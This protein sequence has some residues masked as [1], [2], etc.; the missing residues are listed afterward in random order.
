MKLGR[1]FGLVAVLTAVGLVPLYG[2]PRKSPVTHS[3]WSRMLLR[4]M[5][6]DESVTRVENADAIFRTLAW[7]DEH[8][9]PASKYTRGTDVTKRGNAVDAT[10]AAGESAYDLPIVRPGDYNVRL[11][12]KGAP[13]KPFRVEI[14]KNGGADAIRTF[15]PT[16]NGDEISTVDLGWVT[17]EPGDHT[18]SVA[19]PPGTSLEYVQVAPPCLT[20][21]EPENGWRAAA[22]TTG[23]DL[24]LTMIQAMD[25]Q[26]E[27]APGAEPIEIRAEKF[28]NLSATIKAS[29][30]VGGADQLV[31]NPD[32]V[33]AIAVAEI[34]EDGLYSMSAWVSEGRGQAWIADSCRRST[35]CPAASGA[36]HWRTIM[37]SDFKKGRHTFAVLLADSASVGRLRL[38]KV[39]DSGDDYIAA[40]KRKGFDVG[41]PG[42]IT[43]EKAREAMDWLRIQWKRKF[44]EER[45]CTIDVP[46]TRIAGTAPRGEISGRNSGLTVQPPPSPNTPGTPGGN[47]PVPP[48]PGGG[49]G[50]TPPPTPPPPPATPTVTP[51]PP[52]TPTPPVPPTPTPSPTA[53]PT[54]GPTTISV[55]G[56]VFLDLNGDGIQGPNEPGIPG[57]SVS[58]VLANGTTRLVTTDANGI[59]S[60]VF[61]GPPSMIGPATID[62]VNS[63]LPPGMSQTAGIDSQTVNLVPGPN[64]VGADGYRPPAVPVNTGSL[65]GVVFQDT[66]GNGVQD[67][68]E[69]GLPGVTVIVTDV[70]GLPHVVTTDSYGVWASTDLPPG[71]ATVDVVDATLPAGVTQTAG[72]DPSTA[73][74]VAGQV[75]FGGYDGY[76]PAG[77]TSPSTGAVTGTIFLDSDGDGVRDPGEPGM[78]GVSVIVTASN[79]QTFLVTTDANGNYFV[80]NVPT[81]PATVDV[82]NSTLPPG[83][84]QTAGTDPTSINVTPGAPTNAGLDGY[85]P[86][87]T[88]PGPTGSVTGTIFFDANGNG[89]QDPG[90]P[91]LSG[92][93]VEIQTAG[94]QLIYAT[95]N[96]NGVYTATNVPAGNATVDVVNSTLPAGLTQ[97]AG[98]DPTPV[99]VPPAGTVNAGVDGYT[100][101]AQPT[102]GLTGRVFIDSNGDGVQ[103]PG[104]PGIP[105]VSVVV[106]DSAGNPHVVVTDS[107]GNWTA[108]GLPP[109]NATV[110][111]VNAT[112]P[113]GT[114][115]QTAGTDPNAV[116]VVAG[117]TSNGGVDGYQPPPPVGVTGTITGHVYQDT[118][119][120]GVQNGGEPNLPGVSIVVTTPGGQ[121]FTTLTDGSGNYSVPGVPAGN[122]TVDI[123]NSTLPPG[124]VQT[125]GTDPTTV[126]VP[127][128]GSVFEQNN[129]FEPPSP[130]G[131]GGVTGLVFLDS[132][133]NGSQDGG[134]PGIP[135][136]SVVITASN[137][138]TFVATTDSNGVYVVTN[139]PLGPA[140]VDVVNSTLPPNVTQTAGID[141][142]SVNVVAGPPT[143]AGIDGFRPPSVPP[144]PVGSVTG[145]VYLDTNG[146][147]VRDGGENGISGV[148]VEIVAANGQVFYAVTNVNGDYTVPNVP[149]G[150]AT[151]DVV[152]STLPPNLQQTGG[153]D[154]STVAVPAAGVG[155]A[156]SDG[157]QP[158]Q[159]PSGSIGTVTGVVFLDSNQNGVRDAG[160]PGLPGVQVLLTTSTGQVLTGVTDTD[161]VYSIQNAASGPAT[162][163]VV[164]GTLPPGLNQTAGIDPSPVTVL[165]NT[166]T[167]AGFDGYAPPTPPTTTG[168]VTGLVFQDLNGDGDQDPGELGL[169]GVQVVITPASGPPITVTTGPNG[170]YTAPT[171]PIGSATVD[172]VNSTLPPGMTQT[173]GVDTSTVNVLPGT[174]NNAGI[175][176]YQPPPPPGGGTVTG[177]VFF[178]T[179]NDGVQNPGE[180]GIPGAT[181]T[182]TAANGQTVVVTTDAN[183][184]YTAANVPPGVATVDVVDASLPP[185]VTHTV[186]GI[187]PSTVNVVSNVVNNAGLD[188]YRP[189]TTP[190]VGPTGS[191][192]GVVFLDANG[193]GIQDPNESGL[194]G[195]SVLIT[196]AN[197]Q[198]IPV[199]TDSTG[200]Y[201]APN[202]PPGTATVDVVNSTLPPN[203]AQSAGVDPSTVNV[204]SGQVNNAGIDGY[205]PQ[206]VVQPPATPVLPS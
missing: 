43:R 162:L 92:V 33:H 113:P 48:P 135:G 183:G 191:V 98:V 101:I 155:N 105:G 197:G 8:T 205:R 20:P 177:L 40:L 91:G 173:A 147:G 96:A 125:E 206:I 202:V 3:E 151:V 171:V 73:T 204:L 68:N 90:E 2:D 13:D 85:A 115:T 87:A 133:G 111:V 6:F 15:K 62:V 153:V 195:V 196:A 71:P 57:V 152:N 84:T 179:N 19:L 201:T 36:P 156:G 104:E 123:V 193:N 18:L 185:G 184:I 54:G 79:G 82:V 77:P 166:V 66:N 149:A 61:T 182:I 95:T 67:G 44:E 60:T 136:V 134:E 127:G 76:R 41:T 132:N 163:D 110:D 55:Q 160:E 170:V 9:I 75:I 24:A 165:P 52:P 70:N 178:D 102:G 78:P 22:I 65:N 109:G 143:N 38:Q 180:A 14:R 49:P 93:I 119:G 129:G 199:V 81:G 194:P 190:P 56:V 158:G 189:T 26:N 1:A 130:G 198:I 32:G 23:E 138:Q 72:V 116:N 58:I 100:Q 31:G 122:A 12:L 35:M 176:G 154:P 37:T 126:V 114:L 29:R 30:P 172:I 103:G 108:T 51:T 175:D 186:A 97:S 10:T 16:G 137:G 150:P 5:G 69:P 161:G 46:A 25:W 203:L 88:P 59:Y 139:V 27:L 174:I 86:P 167:N 34:P 21:I 141:P 94:G 144:G 159:P 117:V 181:V 17:M 168:G 4:A 142:N 146:N 107:N 121:V 169:P 164:N 28:Q 188:G 200:T 45:P 64:N 106:T 118:N 89:V 53:T 74:V 112:L 63:T 47:P 11:K 124:L 157:Y 42:P 7:T 128:G 131:G 120:D 50:P 192:T 148:S 187:D 39:K 83:L 80:P 145:N 99:V 140:T